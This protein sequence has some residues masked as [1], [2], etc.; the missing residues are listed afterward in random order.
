MYKRDTNQGLR[1]L[2]EWLNANK[3]SLNVSKTEIIIFK[4]PNKKLNYE[5]KV[6]IDDNKLLPSK[7]IDF[8]LNWSYHT[9]ILSAK[10]SRTVGMLS[11]IRH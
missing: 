9:D 10:L 8:D 11:K 7:C 3:V 5:L 1:N 6:N 4:H 2:C